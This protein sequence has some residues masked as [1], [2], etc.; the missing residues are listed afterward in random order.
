MILPTDTI[1]TYSPEDQREVAEFVRSPIPEWPKRGRNGALP[2][3]EAIA[4]HH[5]T[6]D[7]H[8]V[9]K[10]RARLRSE[11]YR[12]GQPMVCLQCGQT[13]DPYGNLFCGH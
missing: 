6:Q 10:A 11:I 2:L 7:M 13:T 3:A 9:N 4:T 8:E 5:L 12:N 1:L